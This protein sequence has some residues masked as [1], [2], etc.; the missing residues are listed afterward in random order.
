MR[1]FKSENDAMFWARN[2]A[3]EI[4]KKV[5]LVSDVVNTTKDPAIFSRGNGD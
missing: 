1:S 5:N 4:N 2:K 3:E